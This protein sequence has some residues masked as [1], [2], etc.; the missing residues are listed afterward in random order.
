MFRLFQINSTDEEKLS[1]KYSAVEI[2]P[3]YAIKYYL[4]NITFK[5]RKFTLEAVIVIIS[6]KYTIWFIL[7]LQVSLCHYVNSNSTWIGRDT[8]L[9]A[10]QYLAM[11]GWCLSVHLPVLP[12]SYMK[13]TFTAPLLWPY[14]VLVL[15]QSFQKI[16]FDQR[17]LVI[18]SQGDWW[19]FCLFIMII[20]LY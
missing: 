9:G 15:K 12:V 14:D 1:W 20:C 13:M 17:Q 16:H 7:N 4:H 11:P 6:N 18:L 10:Y 5:L 8:I 2:C 19:F 3:P